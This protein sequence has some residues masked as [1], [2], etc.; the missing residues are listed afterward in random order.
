MIKWEDFTTKP[1][2][3]HGVFVHYVLVPKSK[4]PESGLKEPK[5]WLDRGSGHYY[6]DIEWVIK[7]NLEIEYSEDRDFPPSPDDYNQFKRRE[8]AEAVAR[9]LELFF[10]YLHTPIDYDRPVAAEKDMLGAFNRARGLCLEDDGYG[11][12]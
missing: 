9:A 11:R 10:E 12:I 4:E 6:M 2:Y 3:E 8:T 1:I 7:Q 5:R